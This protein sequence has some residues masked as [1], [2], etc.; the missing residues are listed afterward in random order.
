MAASATDYFQ[1]VGDSTATTLSAP[2]YTIGAT[3]INVGST[4]NWPTDTGVTFAIDE[5]DADGARI[6]GTYNTFRGVVSS[7]TQISSL[8]YMGGDANRN[9]SAG[10]TTRVYIHVGEDRE[11]RFTDGILIEHKQTGAHRMTSP[12][13]ITAINDTNGNELI[14]VVATASAVNEIEVTNAAT[15]GAPQIAATGGDTD[16]NLRIK[17]KGAGT[18]QSGRPVAF[19]ATTTQSVANSASYSDITTYTEVFDYG[20]NFNHTTG[21][22]TAP[23][24]G[25]YCFVGNASYTDPTAATS[26]FGIAI[27]V[28]GTDVADQYVGP[29]ATNHDPAIN[30]SAIVLLA[31]SDQV[32]M[33]VYQDSG[34]S[35]ALRVPSHFS[36]YLIG[37]T[38]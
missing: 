7:G 11:N 33:R 21:I 20:A 31:A 16:V 3:S 13:V 4:T 22:F 12:E 14:K 27:N 10:A 5:V 1:K 18:T 34:A 35:E 19:N 24:A 23:Y 38:D 15:G 28:G 32:K 37:R 6:A 9:Y 2:G 30:C 17:A 25:V 26:R 29:A 8:T 36:G